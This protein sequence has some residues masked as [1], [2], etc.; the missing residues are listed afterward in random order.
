MTLG[1]AEPR[2]AHNNTVRLREECPASPGK[3]HPVA[4]IWARGQVHAEPGRPRTGSPRRQ[5]T[6]PACNITKASRPPERA[7]RGRRPRA[8]SAGGSA[9]PAPRGACRSTGVAQRG[10]PVYRRGTCAMGIARSR[11]RCAAPADAP[12]P[13]A[14]VAAIPARR[15]C[16][17]ALSGC[18]ASSRNLPRARRCTAP[19]V[20]RCMPGGALPPQPW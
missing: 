19:R 7:K 17:I 3:P 10:A 2:D 18:A 6:P 14:R 12:P 13:R 5:R 11:C 8:R 20:R 9:R 1:V 16:R 15:A 4:R